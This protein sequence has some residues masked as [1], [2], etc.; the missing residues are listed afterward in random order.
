MMSCEQRLITKEYIEPTQY[1]GTL[2]D[3][4]FTNIVAIF[5]LKIRLHKWHNFCTGNQQFLNIVG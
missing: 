2:G 4:T 1:S 5:M 3:K